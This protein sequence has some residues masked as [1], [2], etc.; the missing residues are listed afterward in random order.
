MKK[1]LI[2]GID[3]YE[4]RFPNRQNGVASAHEITQL[5]ATNEGYSDS[6]GEPNFDCKLITG[7]QQGSS[8][9]TRA[10]IK[11]HCKALLEDEEADVALLYFSG[12]GLSDESGEFLVTQDAE[13]YD[14]GFALNDLMIYVNNSSIK[15]INIILNSQYRESTVYK[16]NQNYTLLRK[17]VSIL[18]VRNFNEQA[19]D[20]FAELMIASLNGSN[21]DYLGNVTFLEL[22]EQSVDILNGLGYLIDFKSNISRLT[23]LRKTRPKISYDLLLKIRSYFHQPNYYYK[24]DK[25]HIPSQGLGNERKQK[26]YK[27]LQKLLKQGLVKPVNAY[28]MYYAALNEKHC[29][30]TDRG[31]QYWHLLEQKI[32]T[33]SK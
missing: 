32:T 30:L 17:G 24:L 5:L 27:Q 12:Y 26:E 13:E 31:K 19:K 23:V 7:S 2:I 28:H 15:E 22:Y 8:K 14:E 21:A 1:A 3:Q 4:P 20:L 9:V 29:K 18:S 10:V 33:I 11:Q 6:Q 16:T 25:E